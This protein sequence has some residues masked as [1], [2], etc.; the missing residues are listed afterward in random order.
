MRLVGI[1]L[2][3]M[4][5]FVAC[6]F[7]A[8]LN[9]GVFECQTNADCPSGFRCE[10][11]RCLGSNPVDGG[12]GCQNSSQCPAGQACVQGRCE[13][14]DAG[15][16][17]GVSECSSDAN[18]PNNGYCVEGK[19]YKG[20]QNDPCRRPEQC[21]TGFVCEQ[22]FG[23]SRCLKRCEE[24]A[25]CQLE[26]SCR[27]GFTNGISLCVPRCKEVAQEGCLATHACVLHKG[28]GYCLER[29]GK[30]LEGL[31]CNQ[32]SDCEVHLYCRPVKDF[33]SV[34]R[35]ATVCDAQKSEGCKESGQA[36]VAFPTSQGNFPFGYCQPQPRQG[37]EGDICGRGD[38]ICK[39]G[40]ICK[41]EDPF[42]RCR[43]Q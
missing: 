10:Q 27:P 9:Q 30:N 35:C 31:Q 40:L 25:V 18:C 1:F 33:A 6:T 39:P 26:E 14:S 4:A 28:R 41:T 36:C 38:L 12:T 7:S 22:L 32:D 29:R 2:M 34:R 16:A 8:D 21:Q 20:T 19:C 42:S 17:D 3:G 43:T 23:I 11:N 24:H 13:A 37:N 5:V 15:V